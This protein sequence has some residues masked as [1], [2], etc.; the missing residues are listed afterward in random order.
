M[1][2]WGV[3]VCVCACVRERERERER[4]RAYIS[5]VCIGQWVKHTHKYIHPST[6]RHTHAKLKSDINK[7]PSII[8]IPIHRYDY[9]ERDKNGSCALVINYKLFIVIWVGIWTNSLHIYDTVQPFWCVT[10][11]VLLMFGKILPESA[12]ILPN[13]DIKTLMAWNPLEKENYTTHTHTQ[14]ERKRER[15]TDRQRGRDFHLQYPGIVCCY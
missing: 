5:S 4:E 6:R 15:Q 1:P 12:V 8:S 3:C 2:F 7:Y 9:R 14:R 13:F 11:H 10:A